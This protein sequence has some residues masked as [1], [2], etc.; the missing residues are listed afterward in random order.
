MTVA[1]VA[2]ARTAQAATA[3]ATARHRDD[4]R[5]VKRA[6]RLFRKGAHVAPRA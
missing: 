1:T 6:P 5:P 2:T 4:N 3:P